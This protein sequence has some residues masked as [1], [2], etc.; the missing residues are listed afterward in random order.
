MNLRFISKSAIAKFK[1]LGGFQIYKR[2]IVYFIK[3][4]LTIN[5]NIDFTS[6]PMIIIKYDKMDVH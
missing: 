1:G 6:N 4:K 3:L 5:E 2:D